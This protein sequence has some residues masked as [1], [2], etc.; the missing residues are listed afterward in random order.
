M[1]NW[2]DEQ[3]LRAALEDDIRTVAT[4]PPFPGKR[5]GEKDG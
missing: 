1:I 2:N 5:G 4:P 3:D